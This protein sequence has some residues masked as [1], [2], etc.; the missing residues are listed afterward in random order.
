MESLKSWITTICVAVIFITAVEMIL[1]DNSL[2]KYSKFVL[3]L[4]LMTVILNPIIKL[5][6]DDS[7]NLQTYFNKYDDIIKVN[8]EENKEF[9]N[10]N[11]ESTL[12]NFEMNIA[13]SCEKLLKKKYPKDN[14]KIETKAE[15]DGKSFNI[16]KIDI[17][18]EKDSY[19]KPIEKIE[20]NT[21]S[22][23]DNKADSKEHTEKEE[24]ILEYISE[25]LNVEKEQVYVYK[26][27]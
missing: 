21:N 20:I 23:M 9:K 6:V 2:K 25:N 1:P 27:D 10:K 13:K 22:F 4:I 19:V 5:F 11:M 18:F 17:G 14:F 12:K 7:I 24:N 16:S 3:G 26:L 8:K 15:Y